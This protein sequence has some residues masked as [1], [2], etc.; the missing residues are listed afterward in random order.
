MFSIGDGKRKFIYNYKVM[1]SIVSN[2][3]K[4][5]YPE[6]LTPY[7]KKLSFT[8]ADSIFSNNYKKEKSSNYYINKKKSFQ[9]LQKQ[10]QK[11]KLDI[12]INKAYEKSNPIRNYKLSAGRPQNFA[13]TK[14]NHP[15][16]TIRNSGLSIPSFSEMVIKQNILSA[17]NHFFPEKYSYKQKNEDNEDKKNYVSEIKK[18]KKF[19]EYKRLYRIKY[20][21]QGPVKSFDK[22]TVSKK[23]AFKLISPAITIYNSKNK[24]NI[25]IPGII[26]NKDKKNK[27]ID[28]GLNTIPYIY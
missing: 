18:R 2:P 6:Y 1:E 28:V 25:I 27:K 8:Y 26:S 16:I 20:L 21:K 19:D 9:K 14:F 17:A 22:E 3:P 12:L 23:K 10:I 13:G 24:K 4:V 11:K 5:R 7:N 15:E